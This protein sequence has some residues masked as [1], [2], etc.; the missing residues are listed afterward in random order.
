MNT[1]IAKKLFNKLQ[2]P[3]YWMLNVDDYHQFSTAVETYKAAGLKVKYQEIDYPRNGYT[4]IFWI[5]KKP[6]KEIKQ[7]EKEAHTYTENNHE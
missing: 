5:G 4:A 1:T 7:L 6:I 2:R 3:I